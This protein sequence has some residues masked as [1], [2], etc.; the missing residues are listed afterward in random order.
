MSRTELRYDRNKGMKSY[1]SQY[2]NAFTPYLAVTF[3]NR[4]HGSS[5]IPREVPATA[6]HLVSSILFE[7]RFESRGRWH[8]FQLSLSLSRREKVRCD[9]LGCA[10]DASSTTLMLPTFTSGC[11]DGAMSSNKFMIDRGYIHGIPFE[12]HRIIH[13]TDQTHKNFKLPPSS[14]QG[15][16][17]D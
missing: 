3:L 2:S 5:D 17:L 8:E 14:E 11:W 9:L 16:M 6:E 4:H 13:S 10:R 1:E 15:Q 7:I 12:V